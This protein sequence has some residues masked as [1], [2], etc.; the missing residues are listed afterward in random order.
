MDKYYTK[1]Y[2]FILKSNLV[3]TCCIWMKQWEWIKCQLY[4]YFVIFADDKNKNK[5]GMYA[6]M[7]FY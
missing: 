7:L 1:Y 5:K 4:W 6:S 2:F 3:T